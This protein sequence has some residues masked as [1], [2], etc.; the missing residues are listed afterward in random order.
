MFP[1]D[2]FFPSILV[3]VQVKKQKILEEL[4]QRKY[5]FFFFQ[6]VEQME[7]ANMDGPLPFGGCWLGSQMSIF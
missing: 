1:G 2:V 6:L 3:M 4:P 7:I 5:G